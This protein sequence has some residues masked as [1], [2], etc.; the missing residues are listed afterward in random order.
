MT[1]LP[2]HA[3]PPAAP[4]G[5][6]QL[7]PIAAL[8]PA[9]SP[10]AVAE[11]AGHL[12]ALS[13]T[14]G[15]LPPI[16]VH[17]PSMRI[18]DG[19]HRVRAAHLRGRSH[20]EA[21]FFDGTADDAFVLAV[22]SNVSHGLALTLAERSAAAERILA[23]H[24]HWSDRAIASSTGLS[25]HTVASLRRTAPEAQPAA[26][27]GRDGKVRPLNTAQSRREAG[28]LLTGSPTVSLR[29]VARRTGLAPATVRD[30]RDRLQ[31]GED[32]VPPQQA[33]TAAPQ[34]APAPP[35][36]PPAP[37]AEELAALHR[38]LC[39]DPAL[40]HTERGRQLLRLLGVALL[41]G[42]D[43]SALAA[44]V[45]AHRTRAVAELASACARGW[46][47]FAQA[48]SAAASAAGGRPGW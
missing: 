47:S 10:R 16:T 41:P 7:L 24:P 42:A 11:D 32:P 22:E 4:V 29:E 30:V 48:E 2:V 13:T 34:P 3:L 9:D 12:R 45:P 27:I 21:R 31:R 25:A 36:P 35:A 38:N 33:G 39:R 44:T 46:E 18:I 40:R 19:T 17:R 8:R 26:R 28:R 43:W 5:A 1:A 23:S 14:E 6:V 20:I 15:A 37:P